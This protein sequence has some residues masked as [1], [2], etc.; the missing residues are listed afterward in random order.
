[1]VDKENID[2]PVG[3]DSEIDMTA[4]LS[5][6]A[7]G[8][9]VCPMCNTKY[10]DKES[11]CPDCGFVVMAKDSAIDVSDIPAPSPKFKPKGFRK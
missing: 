5:H 11:A 3:F 1:M 6:M 4:V 2:D 10:L 7:G 9:I 8:L